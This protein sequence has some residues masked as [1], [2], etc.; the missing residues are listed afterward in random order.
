[1]G[2][3]AIF[4]VFMFTICSFLF[5][6]PAGGGTIAQ[7]VTTAPI[8]VGDVTVTVADTSDFVDVVP[9]GIA[10]FVAGDEIFTYTGKNP[11]HFTGVVGGRSDPQIASVQTTA[12]AHA[13]GVAVKSLA[14]Q[15]IDSMLGMNVTS[16]TATFGTLQAFYLAGRLFV[17]FPKFL[18]WNYPILNSGQ[19]V[20]LKYFILYP[21]SAGFVFAVAFGFVILAM[22][23]FHT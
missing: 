22:G 16:S 19:L 11:T 13:S 1:M 18:L 14:V 17:N 4:F 7:T 3:W 12:V 5:A 8:A 15:T 20:M 9:G 6:I 23:V 10:Y 21:L 2:R